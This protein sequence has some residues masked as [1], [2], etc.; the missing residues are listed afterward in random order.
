MSDEQQPDAATDTTP[1]A[2]D[3]PDVETGDTEADKFDREY[4]QKVRDEAKRYRLSAKAEAERADAHAKRLFVELVRAS[5]KLADPRDM[6]F[7]AELLDDS[8]KLDEAIDALIAERPHLKAR[9][10]ITGDVGQGRR[11]T[12]ADCPSFS[13]LLRGQ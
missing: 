1:F 11:G 3:Q 12:S 2:E 4:V 10:V 9:T 5:G 13:G 8:G 7:V 6:P